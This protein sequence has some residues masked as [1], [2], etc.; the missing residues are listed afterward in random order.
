DIQ[1]IGATTID[2]YRKSIEKDTGLERRLQPILIEE[3][4]K[5]ESI[6]I[7]KG[8]KEKYENFHSV[9]ITEEAIKAA[10]DLSSRYIVDRYLPDKA[11]DI[12]DESASR[13]RM[14]NLKLKNNKPTVNSEI[15]TEVIGLWTGIPISKIVKSE[16]DKLL[17]LESILHQRVIG[18]E[19]AVNAVSKAVRRSR[20]GLKDPKRPIGSFLFL[21]PTGVGKTELCKALAEA[22]FGNENQIIRIDMSEYMEK[23]SVSKLI[24]SPPGYIG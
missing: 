13:I 18:Q 12:I 21:G 2:E 15:V 17:N 14:K 6:K 11:V 3:P 24:G 23:H 5:E 8:L 1:V 9:K 10:V 4:T 19:E 16:G 7:L 20:A 22:H